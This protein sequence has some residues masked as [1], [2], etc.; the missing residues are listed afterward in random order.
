MVQRHVAIYF[1]FYEIVDLRYVVVFVVD[2]LVE[3]NKLLPGRSHDDVVAVMVVGVLSD[4]S[5]EF[6][7]SFLID[8]LEIL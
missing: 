7:F 6:E 3:S 8:I 5:E 2:R 1:M 4:G